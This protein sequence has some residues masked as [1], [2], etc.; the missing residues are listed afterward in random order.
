M[1][2]NDGGREGGG[3]GGQK[4]LSKPSAEKQPNMVN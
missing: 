1:D 2:F 4:V 3:W